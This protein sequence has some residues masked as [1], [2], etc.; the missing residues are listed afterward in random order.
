MLAVRLAEDQ[1]VIAERRPLQAPLQVDGRQLRRQLPEVARRGLRVL[2]E[3]AEAP[4]RRR[5]LPM[6]AVRRIV[7]L[8]RQA[9]VAGQDAQLRG[10]WR[11][12][13]A[14]AL[15]PGDGRLQFGQRRE[16]LVIGP[17]GP[18]LGGAVQVRRHGRCSWS[19][20]CGPRTRCSADAVQHS[21][22]SPGRWRRSSR[23]GRGA[24]PGTAAQNGRHADRSASSGV[25][26]S[27]LSHCPSQFGDSQRSQ[28]SGPPTR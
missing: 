14:L 2:G 20:S 6:L 25:A 10:A 18:L 7:Q 23:R 19:Y 26:G 27:S 15:A 22:H 17:A 9:V 21:G 8:D 4:V 13:P 12:R 1:R 3:L 24:S 5:D 16:A 28:R 11:R